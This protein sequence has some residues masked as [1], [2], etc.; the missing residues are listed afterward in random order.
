[1]FKTSHAARPWL[2]EVC[3]ATLN[4]AYKLRRSDTVK[5]VMVAGTVTQDP[6]QPGQ[7]LRLL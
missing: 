6:Q 5:G 3:T 2:M 4:T 7:D 1:M